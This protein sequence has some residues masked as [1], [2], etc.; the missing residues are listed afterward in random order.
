MINLIL[1]MAGKYTRFQKLGYRIPKYLYPLADSTVLKKILNI[2]INSYPKLNIY[3][4]VN[5]ADKQ[6]Y[7]VIKSNIQ[8]IKKPCLNFEFIDDTA[9]Q[10]ETARYSQTLF[11]EDIN[12]NP[13]VFGNID[14]ILLNRSCFFKKLD[15]NNNDLN[16]IDTFNATSRE[17]SYCKINEDNFVVSV[18]DKKVISNISCSGLY[19]FNDPIMFFNYAEDLLSQKRSASFSDFLNFIIKK[20]KNVLTSHNLDPRDTIVLGTPE[21]YLA[22]LHKF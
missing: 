20:N 1:T 16:L 4:I 18:E 6:F 17:Y 9:G 19:G 8:N 21:E 7:P 15:I 2:Y 14:T 22:N 3:L 12:S 10:L 11:N 13:I 5:N